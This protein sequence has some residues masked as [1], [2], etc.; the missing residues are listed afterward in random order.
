[1]STTLVRADF[2]QFIAGILT[3]VNDSPDSLGLHI[4]WS[5][6]TPSFFFQPTGA[7]F[8]GQGVEHGSLVMVVTPAVSSGSQCVGLCCMMSQRD[9]RPASG[10]TAYSAEFHPVNASVVLRKLTNGFSTVG[11]QLA[12]HTFT[13]GAFSDFRLTWAVGPNLDWTFLTVAIGGAEQLRYQ[14]LS[15]PYTTSV[16]EGGF[17]HDGGAGLGFDVRYHSLVLRG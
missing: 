15:S 9:M 14:D 1:M 7:A 5:V 17:Y 2:E 4:E 10:G 8:A 16:S 12:Q 3:V 13:G 6:G 11:T